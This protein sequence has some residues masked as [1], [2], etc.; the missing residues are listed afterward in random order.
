MGTDQ[1][2]I[3]TQAGS[4]A[5][6]I[7]SRNS[8][9]YSLQ[10]IITSII[11]LSSYSLNLK[12]GNWTDG[13]NTS[14]N[15]RIQIEIFADNASLSFYNS[16]PLQANDHSTLSSATLNFT[17][18]ANTSSITIKIIDPGSPPATCGAVVDDLY[19][20]SPLVTSETHNSIGCN[21]QSTGSFTVNASGAAAPYTGTYSKD[22]GTPVS[23]SF[24]GNSAS[25]SSLNAGSYLVNVIDANGCVK[26]IPAFSITQPVALT[27]AFTKISDVNCFGGA[28]GSATLVTQGGAPGYTYTWNKDGVAISAP[29]LTALTAGVYEVIVADQS[30]CGTITKTITITQPASSIALSGTQV[31]VNCFGGTTG[32]IDLSV[33]GGTSPYSYVWTNSTQTTQDLSGLGA[34]TYQVTVTDVKGCTATSTITITQPTGA[35]TLSPAVTDVSCFGTATGSIDLTVS[36]GTASYSYVWKNSANDV[37]STSQDV[38]NLIGGSYSVVVTD[39]NGCTQTQ[40]ATI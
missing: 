10:Q 4:N 37:I 6:K 27:S 25:V 14:A 8:E 32:A 9:Q 1:V 30:S 24:T 36:G 16:G 28:T 22:G 18:P 13:C 19:I 20:A 3:V 11:P 39:A 5:A 7:R 33:T 15:A 38:T 17:V 2:N 23:F 29:I 34:N 40:T 26:P 31:N 35:L 12:Y 21:G